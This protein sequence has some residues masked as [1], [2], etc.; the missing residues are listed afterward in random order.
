M[1]R[2][3]HCW[4][5]ELGRLRVWAA[6]VGAHQKLHSSLDYRLRAA[7]HIQE[8]VVKLLLDLTRAVT[9]LEQALKGGEE[10]EKVED[11]EDDLEFALALQDEADVT[12]LQQTYGEVVDIVN[13]VFRMSMLIR[14]PARHAR[15]INYQDEVA[16]AFEPLDKKHVLEKFPH[17]S[18]SIIERLGRANTRRRNDLRYRERHHAKLGQGIEG[19][20]EKDGDHTIVVS[21]TVASDFEMS[22]IDYD[23]AGS[24][25]GLSMTSYG[26]IEKGGA[27]AVPAPPKESAN[28]NPFE[29]PYCYFIITIKNRRAWTRH[30]FKDIMPYT[31]VFPNCTTPNKMYER[32]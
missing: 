6:I 10:E 21:E 31:C 20:D 2:K 30:V 4:T 11:D 16:M 3:S 9:E 13:N 23:D 18:N 28:E 15:L 24:N 22:H 26:S 32:R 17:A 12:E 7:V 29:C 19:G 1:S 5:D 14:K 25:S 27:I 8:Q